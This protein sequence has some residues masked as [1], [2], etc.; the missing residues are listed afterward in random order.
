MTQ[1]TKV[2]EQVDKDRVQVIKGW[3]AGLSPEK[4]RDVTVSDLLE[5]ISCSELPA[6]NRLFRS[7]EDMTPTAFLLEFK[8]KSGVLDADDSSLVA[9]VI[10]YMQ[11]NIHRPD[12][13]KLSKLAGRFRVKPSRLT[14]VFEKVTGQNT[15]GYLR[16]L[17]FE[18]AKTAVVTAVDEGLFNTEPAEKIIWRI[19]VRVCGY[20]SP[21]TLNKIFEERTEEGVTFEKYVRLAQELSDTKEDSY[22]PPE[23]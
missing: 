17:H 4:L 1:S 9:G 11:K 8:T 23:A 3:L 13:I 20:D 22:P 14:A 2:V 15:S 16:E 6:I 19:A 12:E 18:A 21:I 7:V 5:Q 10:D